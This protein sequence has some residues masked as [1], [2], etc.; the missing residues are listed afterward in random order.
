MAEPHLV[1]G[2]HAARRHRW[3]VLAVLAAAA[4]VAVVA[5]PSPNW[6]GSAQPEPG[7]SAAPGAAAGTAGARSAIPELEVA[8]LLPPLSGE[9]RGPVREDEDAPDGEADGDQRPHGVELLADPAHHGQDQP[10]AHLA[11]APPS[12]RDPGGPP[13]ARVAA[14]F[15]AAVPPEWRAAIPVKL[16]LRQG[17]QSR[18]Y[19][20]GEVEVA[21][22]H[23]TGEWPRLLAITAH[24]FAH[25]LAFRRGTGAYLG[26]PPAGWEHD[27]GP[28]AEVWA[29]CVAKALT[30]YDLRSYGGPPCSG[31]ALESA[32][33][34]LAA[35][36]A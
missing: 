28:A 31:R 6:L 26:A 23:A 8:P 27:G 19:T 5:V 12:S 1:V 30:G 2:G 18:A 14:A 10:V 33:A 16:S 13:G 34:Y 15:V 21:L 35:G 4:V 17:S 11:P 36:P 29:D 25:Q 24:E 20:D 7:G 9:P 22:A 3:F 32:S